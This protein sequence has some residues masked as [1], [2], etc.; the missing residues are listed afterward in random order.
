MVVV[1][2]LLELRLR[3]AVLHADLARITPVL[4]DHDTRGTFLS[5]VSQV[6]LGVPRRLVLLVALRALLVVGRI[7]Q[8]IF[9][10]L[11]SQHFL[12][13]PG[14]VCVIRLF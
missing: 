10:A 13:F 3:F 2:V 8:R 4:F 11:V 9:L 6:P 5:A 14:R 12:K 7:Q 1:D